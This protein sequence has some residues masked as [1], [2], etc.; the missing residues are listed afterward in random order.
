MLM[1]AVVIAVHI[2]KDHHHHH[3]R[4]SQQAQHQHQ[5]RRI[6]SSTG[7]NITLRI[8]V[9]VAAITVTVFTTISYTL[10]PRPYCKAIYQAAKS[11]WCLL[12]LT[13]NV[14]A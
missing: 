1:T 12:Q 13:R 14:L 2:I 10:E 11:H 6:S 5:H 8:I 4:Q 9:D 3:H 7:S